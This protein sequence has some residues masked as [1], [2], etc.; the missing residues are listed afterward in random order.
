MASVVSYADKNY[1]QK[2]ALYDIL[3]QVF[4]DWKYGQ[5][6]TSRSWNTPVQDIKGATLR[7]VGEEH[8]EL[9][10]HHYEVTTV[11]GLARQNLTEDGQKAID[12]MMESICKEFKEVTG[13]TL[14]VKKIRNDQGIEK[15]SRISAET[16]WMLG[17]SRYGYGARPV[18]RYLVRDNAIYEFD[19]EL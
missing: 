1:Q 7:L 5:V 14:K 11:E 15:A 6:H 8:L 2:K 16:S 12:A 4:Q 10:Y 3:L 13:K 19:A 18:G 9:T 17:S